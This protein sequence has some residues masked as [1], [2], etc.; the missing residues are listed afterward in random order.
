MDL[1]VVVCAKNEAADLERGLRQIKNQI[2]YKNLIVVYGTSSD[3]TKEIAEAFTDKVF[4]DDDRGLGAARNLGLEKASSEIVAMIDADVILSGEWY[5]QI[6][7]NF[8]DPTVAGA[9]GTCIYGYGFKPIESYWEYI[10]HT[11]ETNVGCHSAMLRRELVLNVGGFD[12]SI[13]GAGEDYELVQR[14]KKAGYR[15]IWVRGADVYHPM[16]V[17]E[18]FHHLLWWSRGKPYLEE[19]LRQLRT[20]SLFRWY[21]RQVLLVAK[22]FWVGLK[23]SFRENPTLALSYPAIMATIAYARMTELKKLLVSAAKKTT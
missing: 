18:Y 14:L 4:W 19:E 17:L 22:S 1:D 10:R 13:K 7:S 11:G 20:I 9:I 2:P 16:H 8:K 15:W 23:I 12:P 21:A 3:A 6:I 5:N